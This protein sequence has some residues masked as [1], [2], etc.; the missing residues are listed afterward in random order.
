MTLC[1]HTLAPLGPFLET[2]P[3][4]PLGCS[5][6]LPSAEALA[7]SPSALGLPGSSTCP[8]ATSRPC[9]LQVS[10]GRCAQSHLWW[11]WSTTVAWS[12]WSRPLSHGPSGLCIRGG[13]AWLPQRLPGTGW[14][15]VLIAQGLDSCPC[16]W[17]VPPF[18]PFTVEVALCYPH[19]TT[20][21]QVLTVVCSSLGTTRQPQ[22]PPQMQLSRP[23]G[24][25]LGRGC[26][27]TSYSCS[28][29]AGL[30]STPHLCSPGV[31]VC[32]FSSQTAAGVPARRDGPAQ[33]PSCP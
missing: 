32:A 33:L 18:Q 30:V 19:S 15:F 16:A 9:F 3:Q 4:C 2:F 1:P 22:P 10:S 14:Y 8:L 7:A 24:W 12:L 27:H 21:G 13:S 5:P 20:S 11:T 17:N 6:P 29:R 31:P 28:L 26:L 23:A 25:W